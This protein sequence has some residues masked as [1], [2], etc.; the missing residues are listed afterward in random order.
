MGHNRDELRHPRHTP[1]QIVR[2]GRQQR[3]R[4]EQVGD[5]V[6]RYDQIDRSMVQ[7]GGHLDIDPGQKTVEQHN[8]HHGQGHTA[9][10][11]GQSEFLLDQV[12]EC[13]M[14]HEIPFCVEIVASVFIITTL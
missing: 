7:I 10:A 1:C 11:E 4:A 6:L 3:G 5:P 8:Q 13:Q 14:G 2:V 12:T 9:D